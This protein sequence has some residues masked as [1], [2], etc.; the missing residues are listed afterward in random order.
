MNPIRE[1]FWLAEQALEL[2]LLPAISAG[3]VLAIIF[4]TVAVSKQKPRRFGIWKPWYWL[5]F[6]QLL[7]FP[8]VLTIAVLGGVSYMSVAPNP[9]ASK[10]VD[11][12]LWMSLVTGAIWIY[13]LNGAR[14][15]V[16]GFIAVQEIVL[17]G[18]FLVAAMATSGRWL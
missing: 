14:W 6:T 5:V 17:F 15:V 12:L 3:F 8:V 10:Y 2:L 7:Y 4:V 16:A 9:V 11:V 18:A 13:R 1:F